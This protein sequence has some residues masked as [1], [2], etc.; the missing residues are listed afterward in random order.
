MLQSPDARRF[1]L[2]QV[3]KP[4]ALRRIDS[5]REWQR[6]PS[7]QAALSLTE[8]TEVKAR[9]ALLECA[10]ASAR[11]LTRESCVIQLL[12]WEM[13]RQDKAH[14]G[15]EGVNGAV[16]P[17]AAVAAA[18]AAA[19]SPPEQSGSSPRGDA[20][21]GDAAAS[22]S[23][24]DGPPLPSFPKTAEQR[25]RLGKTIMRVTL[26]RQLSPA[27]HAAV[28]DA[29]FER[30]AA[31]GEVVIRQGDEADNFY[32]VE[33]GDFD[34]FVAKPGA[35]PA[36]GAGKYGKLVMSYVGAGTFGELAM[37]HGAPRAATVAAREGGRGGALWALGRDAFVR[38]LQDVTIRQRRTYQAFLATVPMLSELDPY[39]RSAMA[40]CLVEETH[41]DGESIIR[42]GDPGDAF[43]LLLE[44]SAVAVVT[45]DTGAS[46]EVMTYQAGMYFGEVAL[47]RDEP[48]KATVV[49]RGG[50]RVAKMERDAFRRLLANPLKASLDRQLASYSRVTDEKFV[51]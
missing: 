34:V 16:R 24:A 4:P 31:P 26:F 5:G 20:P 40:D 10:L 44:G 23:D 36:A 51:R 38:I 11:A 15:R 29:M 18:T 39:D 49:A 7:F 42:Q 14:R 1:H 13:T 2:T 12:V 25:A 50:V 9:L 46:R 27:Q 8:A 17:D 33:E 35:P 21:P 41:N 28:V 19:A 45:D 6:T 30:R 32:V 43:Y 37:L 48:R 47:L 22:T 3:S